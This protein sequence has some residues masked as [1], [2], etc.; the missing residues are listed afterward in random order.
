MYAIYSID[1]TSLTSPS[2]SPH[3]D[4]HQSEGVLLY[5]WAKMRPPLPTILV[6]LALTGLVVHHSHVAVFWMEAVCC[7][8]KEI[9]AT[10]MNAFVHIA[11]GCSYKPAVEVRSKMNV[12]LKNS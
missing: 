3:A 5:V 7:I 12:K 8:V 6:Q 4:P 10:V 9:F 11:N 1:S 2:G